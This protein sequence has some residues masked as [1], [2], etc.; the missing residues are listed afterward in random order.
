VGPVSD[1]LQAHIQHCENILKQ[2]SEL[3][4]RTIS[5]WYRAVNSVRP[6]SLRAWV[7]SVV[8]W[9]FSESSDKRWSDFKQHYIEDYDYA[10][11]FSSD[12]LVEGLR[13]VGYPEPEVRGGKS[14]NQLSQVIKRIAKTEN[15]EWRLLEASASAVKPKA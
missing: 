10:H 8:W 14:K 9:D 3:S 1:E 15:L 2:E 12:I 13:S 7:A 6:E 4:Q 11:N 5:A